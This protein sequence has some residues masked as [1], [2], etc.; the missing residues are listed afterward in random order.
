MATTKILGLEITAL[1][2]SYAV[3]ASYAATASYAPAYLPLTG[4]TINGNVTVNGTASIAFLNVSYES[5]SVIYSSGSNQFGDASN[6]TQTL[7]GTVNIKSGPVL[8]TG[9]VIATSGFT[10]SLQ[11]TASYAVTASYALNGGGSAAWGGITGTLSN[12]T[13]LQT[14]LTAKQNK[15]ILF[16]TSSVTTVTGSTSETLIASVAIPTTINNAMLR[17]SFIVRSVT[18]GAGTPRTRIRIGTVASPS[19]VQITAAT[20][21]GTNAI[22]SLGMVSMYRTMPVIGGVSGS[23]KAI[24]MTGNVNAD[25]GQTA[26]FDIV[27]RDFT[28]QQYL[29]Y[30]IA[31]TTLAGQTDCYG[32][33]VENIQ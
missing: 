20:I 4:G 21:L 12:Q 27:S 2:S 26:A 14:E 10:G 31:N 7:W 6:D 17:S 1:S 9:S 3:S 16:C 19:L 29:Y 18:L 24:Q 28:T 25:F 30:T 11:G 15:L 13:D 23:I 8:V 5:A 32:I 22:G 33:L